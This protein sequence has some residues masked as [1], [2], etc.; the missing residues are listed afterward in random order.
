MLDLT[1]TRRSFKGG[2]KAIYASAEDGRDLITAVSEPAD[3]TLEREARVTVNW[4][5]LGAIPP[6]DALA[7]AAAIIAVSNEIKG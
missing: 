5:A 1:I 6:E 3:P 4:S 7:F 2:A